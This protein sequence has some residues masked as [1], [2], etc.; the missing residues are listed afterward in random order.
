M[1]HAKRLCNYLKQSG[2]T[3]GNAVNR[4]VVVAQDT[5]IEFV[6]AGT[7]IWMMQDLPGRLAVL[8]R[9][10]YHRPER[11]QLIANALMQNASSH[12]VVH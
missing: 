3:R 8:K 4:A 12:V 11:V 5:A 2:I 10:T 6:S 1:E 9:Q 7:E